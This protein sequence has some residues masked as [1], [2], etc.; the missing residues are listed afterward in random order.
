M[1]ATTPVRLT[2]AALLVLGTAGAASAQLKLGGMNLEGE[3]ESGLRFNVDD[4]E[5]RR[6]QKFEEYR[7]MGEGLQ[8]EGLRLRLFRPDESYAVEFGGSKWG[9]EDQ[10][11]SL[12]VGRLGL[13]EFRF[14]WDQTPHVFSTDA[15]ML[16]R[17]TSPGVFRLPAG[18]ARALPADGPAYNAAPRLDDISV[19]WDTARLDFRLTPTPDLELNASYTRISKD[20]YRPMGMAFGSPGNDF[21]EVLQ[22]LDHTIHD[23]RLRGAY[24][25]PDWQVQFGYTLSIFE[26]SLASITAD[27]PLSAVDAAFAAGSSVP[28]SGRSSLAPDNVAHTVTLAGGVN[29]PMRTRVNANFSYSLRL[30]DDDFLPHTRNPNI[31]AAAPADLTLPQ[32]SLDG[33]VH[34]I[35]GNLSVVSRP[36]RPLTLSAKYRIYDLIDDKDVVRFVNSV[37]ND[38]ILQTDPRQ[39]GQ[40]GFMRQNLDLD[41]RVQIVRPLAVTV[42]AGWERWDRGDHREV[43]ESDEVF[44]KLALDATPAEWLLA[45]LKYVPSFR[46]INKYN[47]HAHVEHTVFEDPAGA[48]QGQSTLLRKF[49]EAERD[50]H[51]IDLL[52]QIMPTETFTLT[53]T[54]A[55]S[56]DDY[57]FGYAPAGV[58]Q[59]G[60]LDEQTWSA[61]MDLSWAPVERLV[62]NG[63]YMY[64][65]IDKTQRSRS[66]PVTGTSTF[67][68]F[69]YDWISENA[70]TINTVHASLKASLIP[71]VLD[72]HLGANF[73][74]AYGSIETANPTPPT[75]G[76]AAQRATANA[77]V[78]PAFQDTLL[79]VDVALKYHFLKQWTAALKYAFESWDQRDWRTD[80]LN[81]FMP[82]TGSSIWLG[83]DSRNYAAH[84]VGA[85]LSYSFK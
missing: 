63:G 62:F 18:L 60:L 34:V 72:L 6:T 65:R 4:P 14:D 16:A 39:S 69:D 17:E 45:R 19:R 75:S 83:G 57:D 73:S 82:G 24:A 64:E 37:E 38:R 20:G 35:L 50:R 67:D 10:E 9:R 27:N 79:R 23:V 59:L 21:L 7:D 33:R 61:G 31:V 71:K 12:G 30:Q 13:W 49:D 68:F 15:R 76:S 40:W 56:Y 36:L 29:L 48:L 42:G 11:F 47:T 43:A 3:I 28:G 26:N 8:L 53:P 55:W 41:A 70:D 54:F 77:K 5:R 44:G 46:R 25:R 32:N 80:T 66:R 51:K 84:I 52:L 74:T 78:L 22:P 2:L 58:R 81:P 1:R 85:S